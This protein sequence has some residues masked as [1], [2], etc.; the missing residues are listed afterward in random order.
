MDNTV[1]PII[2]YT[3]RLK[4]DSEGNYI[5]N[6]GTVVPFFK[7]EEASQYKRE[8]VQLDDNSTYVTFKTYTLTGTEGVYNVDGSARKMSIGQ[9]ALA[10]CLQRAANLERTIVEKMETIANNTAQ[11]NS[12]TMLLE[13]LSNKNDGINSVGNTFSA[14]GFTDLDLQTFRKYAGQANWD[15]NIS[16]L[17]SK[18]DVWLKN[19]VGLEI[20]VATDQEDNKF[21]PARISGVISTMETKLDSLNTISQETLIEIQSQT[22]KRDQSYDL[23]STMLKSLNSTLMGNAN[24]I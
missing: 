14:I 4:R 24:N 21:T 22:T 13:K 23:I 16:S 5:K 11:I 2:N 19:V 7:L 18:Y 8:R 3:Y 6:D 15:S 1:T 12:L 17:S 9:L 10:I 20:A